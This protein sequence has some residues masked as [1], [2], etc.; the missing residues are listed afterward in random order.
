M[1]EWWTHG[2][3]HESQPAKNF[4]TIK[5][6]LDQ[7]IIGTLKQYISLNESAKRRKGKEAKTTTD[8]SNQT[9]N[10]KTQLKKRFQSSR[11]SVSVYLEKWN[12]INYQ[13]TH[14]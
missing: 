6:L 2:T 4:E 10:L 8:N 1:A 14:D 7:A 5:L 12:M 9:A 13:F 3:H 11:T